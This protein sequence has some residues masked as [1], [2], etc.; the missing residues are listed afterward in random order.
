MG[1]L[2]LFAVLPS[3][4]MPLHKS[5]AFSAAWVSSVADIQPRALYM[6]LPPSA[7]EASP[8]TD[9]IEG[10]VTPVNPWLA[11]P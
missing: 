1:F 2:A 7:P 3:W 10:V 5:S 9:K 4:A 11:A 6:N 8:S